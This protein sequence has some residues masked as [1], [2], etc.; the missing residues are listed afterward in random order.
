MNKINIK[1]MV[2]RYMCCFLKFIKYWFIGQNYVIS[3]DLSKKIKKSVER[4]K[5]FIIFAKRISKW[6]VDI[7]GWSSGS[8]SG[9]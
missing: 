6:Y 7:A 3:N 5:K 2:I 1:L 8:S 4:I 9:S